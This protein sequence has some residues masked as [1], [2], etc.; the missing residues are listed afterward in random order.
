[1]PKDSFFDDDDTVD[2]DGD[3]TQKEDKKSSP[4]KSE[5]ATDDPAKASDE[6]KVDWK[7]KYEAAEAEKEDNRYYDEMLRF[8]DTLEGET[9]DDLEGGKRYREL[10]KLG[11]SAKEAYAAVEASS[12]TSPADK[13]K[14]SKGKSHVNATD[15][16]PTKPRSRMDRTTKTLVDDVFGDSLSADEK[17]ELYKRVT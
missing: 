3:D 6:D 15:F 4:G 12:E 7:A 5:K 8:D 13:A 9:L 17:E 1:M 2:E 14:N 10:R 16:R 11:L